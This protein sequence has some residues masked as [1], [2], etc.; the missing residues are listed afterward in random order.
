MNYLDY[1]NNDL[2]SIIIS[3]LDY[4][5]YMTIIK[6]YPN[7]NY[8]IISK[9]I[10]KRNLDHNNYLLYL[11][12]EDIINKLNINYTIDNLI[13]LQEFHLYYQ[14][15]TTLPNSIGNLTNLQVLDLRDNQ[16]S[17]LPSSI[18]NLTNLQKLNLNTNQLTSLPD[19]IGNLTNL[20][21]LYLYNNQLTQIEIVKVKKLLPNFYL[22]IIIN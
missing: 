16:L 8:Y 21:K 13:N 7:I 22:Y 3:F 15:L 5:D 19:S 12:S 9:L 11:S 10:F 14:K 18:G 2:F 1:I 17:S 20:Q 4:D 6:I